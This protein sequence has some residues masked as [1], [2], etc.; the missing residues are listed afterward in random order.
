MSL[1]SRPIFFP[2]N[3]GFCAGVKAADDYMHNIEQV[4]H[5]SGINIIYGYHELVHNDGV[6]Q[7]HKDQGVVFVDSIYDIPDNSVIVTS[8]HGVGP[9]IVFA[10]ESAGS[11]VFDAICPLVKHTHN[12]VE[13]AR[14]NNEKVI[15][16]CHGKP[17]EVKKL[18]D[19]VSGIVGRLDYV[20]KDGSL[21]YDPIER[22][23]LEL[24]DELDDN[25][26]ST[27]TSEY[28]IISQT[29]LNAEECLY[30]RERIKRYIKERQP[31][32]VISSSAAGDVCRAVYDRQRGVKELVDRHLDR[33]VIATDKKS[34]NGMGYVSLAKQL[35]SESG[36]TTD[37]YSVASAEEAAQLPETDGATGLTASAS[38]PDIVTFAIAK[39][40]G[41]IN[42]PIIDRK[43]FIINGAKPKIIES[44]IAAHMDKRGKQSC[45]TRIKS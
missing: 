8:A 44:K 26:F 1:E 6:I 43:S 24:G 17:G 40:L 42:M 28:R 3:F 10:L 15:Y 37:V 13:M 4:A 12:E 38:T 5:D 27:C 25:I 11:L 45:P 7:S 22:S 34:K 36:V 14:K 32:S 29:T 20:V 39:V 31:D 30:L 19:E 23:Y 41:M 16:V 2:E 21:F 9:E 18:H 35:I 33:I